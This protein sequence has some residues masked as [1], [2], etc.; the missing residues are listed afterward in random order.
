MKPLRKD[1][2]ERRMNICEHF[3]GIQHGTCRAGVKYDDVRRAKTDTTPF[4]F[5]CF[6][7]EAGG[8]TCDKAKWL[9]REEAEAEE[10]E[11][12]AMWERT[13][14]AMHAAHDHAKAQGY[15]K[16]R[17]GAGFVDCPVCEK[18]RVYYRVAAYNGHMHASCETDG[19]VSWM[20]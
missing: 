3:N 5:A 8:L 17:A 4:Q 1:P 15:G 2:I 13:S 20:E 12:K 6:Q 14:K 9:T 16:G 7:D 10:A 11:T 19:C 18:G